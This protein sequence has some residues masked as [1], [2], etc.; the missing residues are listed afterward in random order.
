[1]A[2]IVRDATGVVLQ[3]PDE[4]P[5]QAPTV[6][7][8]T[9]EALGYPLPVAGLAYWVQASPDPAS[10]FELST[11][12][13]GRPARIS[14]EGWTIEYLQYFAENPQRPRRIS[15]SREDL[16]IRLVNDSWQP[17]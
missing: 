12:E 7:A 14:Q 2:R 15:L 5:R 11:D 13:R 9:L 16:E 1:V 6:E 4:A 3:L 10:A 17:E 8:L